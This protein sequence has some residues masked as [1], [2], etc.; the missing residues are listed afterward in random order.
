MNFYR[1]KSAR[2]NVAVRRHFLLTSTDILK[3]S[4]TKHI[5]SKNVSIGSKIHSILFKVVFFTKSA[6]SLVSGSI[7]GLNKA[8]LGKLQGDF[9]LSFLYS[10][11]GLI[12]LL[13]KYY[14][15]TRSWTLLPSIHLLDKSFLLS[16]GSGIVCT[17]SC[18][19]AYTARF[20][21]GWIGY[22]S[23]FWEKSIN[24]LIYTQSPLNHRVSLHYRSVY[25]KLLS[26]NLN[27]GSHISCLSGGRS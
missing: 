20:I 1:I 17:V 19:L 18:T 12:G 13:E 7:G 8:F 11:L 21:T 27:Q 5:M 3:L 14:G 22:I 15:G 4:K 10:G 25:Q 9:I 23:Y 24:S 2:L 6:K 16:V 26:W